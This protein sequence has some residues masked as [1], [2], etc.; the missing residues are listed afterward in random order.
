LES[1]IVPKN[2]IDKGMMILLKGVMIFSGYLTSDNVNPMETFLLLA[3]SLLKA[4]NE[5]CLVLLV[6]IF[7][8]SGE[9]V[10]NNNRTLVQ[11]LIAKASLVQSLPL[12]GKI[13]SFTDT[14]TQGQIHFG[15]HNPRI[16]LPPN[17]EPELDGK[18]PLLFKKVILFHNQW[19]IHFLKTLKKFSDI[20]L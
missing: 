13:L 19:I 15:F 7:E 11:S 20:L 17:V 18:Y 2:D 9:T 10:L 1:F 16:S 5:N 4:D 3:S 12:R 14:K 8:A 6:S